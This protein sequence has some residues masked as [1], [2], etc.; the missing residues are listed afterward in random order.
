MEKG[1]KRKG[2]D[3]EES[4]WKGMEGVDGESREGKGRDLAKF[5]EKLMP[6]YT[7]VDKHRELRFKPSNFDV[8]S[9]S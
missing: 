1:R 5:R 8:H 4:G 6:L 9:H 7:A 3:R 2:R